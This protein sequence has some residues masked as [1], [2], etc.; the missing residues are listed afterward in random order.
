[1]K[2]LIDW[3]LA[4]RYVVIAVAVIFAPFFSFV[5]AS[6]IAL[7]LAYRGPVVAIG[8]A[9]IAALAITSIAL[10]T[11][12]SG[13][14]TAAGVIAVALGLGLGAVMRVLRSFNLT[15]QVVLL[16]AYVIVLSYTL[17][18]SGNNELFDE[19]M[20]QITQILR[21]QGIAPGDIDE[22]QSHPLRLV[23]FYAVSALT[24]VVIVLVTAFWALSVARGDD[25]FGTQFRAL[26]LGFVLG[27]PGAA[28]ILSMFVFDADVIHNLLAV[29]AC[30]F[31]L[32][33]LARVHGWAHAQQWHPLYLVPVYLFAVPVV[34]VATVAGVLGIDLL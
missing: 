10:V 9:L 29:A 15:I 28:V 27:V 19:T 17:L 33:G 31:L 22:L 30:G 20:A 7:Q 21:D 23:G 14:A 8:D 11:G 3:A 32:Q 2:E 24:D 13:P 25:L 16:V 5:S 18:G 6:V 1:M 12:V 4:R 34:V 26:R